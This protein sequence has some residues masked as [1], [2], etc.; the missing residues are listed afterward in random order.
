LKLDTFKRNK[1]VTAFDI[2]IPDNDEFDAGAFTEIEYIDYGHWRLPISDLKDF[3]RRYQAQIIP[4][5]DILSYAVLAGIIEPDLD[6]DRVIIIGEE[7]LIPLEAV[8]RSMGYAEQYEQLMF[9]QKVG[10]ARILQKDAILIADMMGLG[11]TLTAIYGVAVDP[12][13]KKT[14]VIC[15]STMKYVWQKE[16][17]QWFPDKKISVVDGPAKLRF[18]QYAAPVEFVVVSYDLVR[19]AEDQAMIAYLSGHGPYSYDSVRGKTG[20]FFNIPVYPEQSGA[21]DFSY[22]LSWEI[23]KGKKLLD[24]KEMPLEYSGERVFGKQ[25]PALRFDAVILDEAHHVKNPTSEQTRAVQ[26]FIKIPKRILLTGTPIMN[27]VEEL[28]ALLNF[29]SPYQFPNFYAFRNK[30]CVMKEIKTKDGRKINLVV[31][32]KNLDYLQKKLSEIMLR[33]NKSDTLKDLPEKTYETRD[34]EL[35]PEQWKLYREFANEI[36]VWIEE[37]ETEIQVHQAL[38]KM[39]RLKQ[40]AISP[41]LFGGT[42]KSSKLDEL[43]DIVDEITSNE[44]K[45]IIFSQFKKATEII[46]ERLKKRGY[47]QK[48]IAY[49][50]GDV[51]MKVS[52]AAIKSGKTDRMEEIRRFQENDDCKIFVGV[53]DACKEGITLTAAN[54]VVF[55]DKKWTPADNE[56]ATDRAHRKGQKNPVT[57]ISLIAKNTIEEYIEEK[58]RDKMDLFDQVVNGTVEVQNTL[59]DVKKMLREIAGS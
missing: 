13:V 25:T 3:W 1:E 6:D 39:L 47:S 21:N 34:I 49:I 16:I 54:Y 28:W 44:Q 15:P 43:E 29:I 41:E 5:Q 12:S 37:S 50:S 27:K 24:T 51:A 14:L 31:A 20:S 53:I 30:Y 8:S 58:L 2:E 57:V 26:N 46:L 11:K 23:K 19:R 32:Y 59:R 7:N 48:N 52:D 33:R 56:Q 38:D 55:V 9:H 42:T 40:V 10:I 4:S 18:Q 35:S 22:N 17:H 36:S 45:V